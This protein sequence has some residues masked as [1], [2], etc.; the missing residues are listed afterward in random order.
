MSCNMKEKEN[1]T[2]VRLAAH[3]RFHLEY[4]PAAAKFLR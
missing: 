1:Q 2:V 3:S 4:E